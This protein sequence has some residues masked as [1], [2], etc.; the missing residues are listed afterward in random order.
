MRRWALIGALLLLSATP[1]PAL[2]D[3]TPTPAMD[4]A[5]AT[6]SSLSFR[7][8]DINSQSGPAGENPSGNMSFSLFGTELAAG[9]VT[10]LSVAGNDAVLNAQTDFGVV[11]VEL[12]DNGGNGQDTMSAI[13][14]RRAATD[15]PPF[16]NAGLTRAP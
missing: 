13:G 4:T 6:A 15:C 16:N 5:V 14:G 9:P 7:D 1:G 10:C 2:A 11:T 12:V 8:M 3:A